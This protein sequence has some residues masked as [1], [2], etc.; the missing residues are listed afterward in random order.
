MPKR[1]KENGAKAR[2]LKALMKALIEAGPRGYQT[3]IARTIG[4]ADSS[5]SR[6]INTNRT[7]FSSC[8]IAATEFVI[9]YKAENWPDD[10]YPVI[11][12]EI[13][14]DGKYKIQT[15]RETDGSGFLV[16]KLN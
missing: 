10:K 15:K 5:I 1:R 8:S 3:V 11:K 7:A 9:S 12:E 14:K 4:M 2:E 16:W 6:A 13:S